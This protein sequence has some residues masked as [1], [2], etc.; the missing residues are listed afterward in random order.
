MTW[1]QIRDNAYNCG[2]CD[3]RKI[4]VMS[5]IEYVPMGEGGMVIFSVK[6]NDLL[7]HQCDFKG[8]VDWHMYTVPLKEVTDL[9]ISVKLFNQK[10]RF[11]HNGQEFSF[12][13]FGIAKPIKE[14]MAQIEAEANNK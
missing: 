3:E 8:N 12:M 10:F 2:I 13:N 7:V 5:V 11:K 14:M 4:A 9:K 1:Q 6:G